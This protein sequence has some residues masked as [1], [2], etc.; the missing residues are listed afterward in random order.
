MVREVLTLS[1]GQAGI[2]LGQ[3][4]WEQYCAEHRIAENG[5]KIENDTADTT[6]TCFFQETNAGQY[7]PRNLMV[8][9]EPNV[10]DDVRN[11]QFC[12]IFHPEFLLNGKEDAANNFARGHYTV[13][14]DMMDKIRDRLRKLAD[15]CENL[16]GFLMNH[17]VGGGTGSGLGAL[18]LERIAMDYRKKSKIGFEIY[19]SPTM[20]TCVV[21]PYN[22]LLAT[23]WLTDHTEV[24]L[25]LDNEAIYEICQK[26]LDIKHPSYDNLNRLICK[27]ISSMTASLRFGG[28]LNVDLCEFQT[29]LV[30]FPRL[31]FMITAMAPI[32]TPKKIDVAATTV[33]ALTDSCFA[34]SN[35]FTKIADFDAQE[36]KY[37]AI[38]VSYRGSVNAKEASSTINW[39]K[40]KKKICF[41]DWVPT[42]FKV[43]LNQQPPAVLANDDVAPCKKNVVMIGNNTAIARVFSER[44]VKKYDVMYSQRAFVHWYVGE[45]MEEGELTE[46]REDLESLEKDY[47]DVLSEDASDRDDGNQ[48]EEEEDD[49]F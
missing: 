42:G 39:L 17:S 34:P 29:N 46:A 9:L 36:D 8:D 40:E 47:L 19:P 13:G 1:V 28:E 23:H 12:K 2:Q 10:I 48:D 15:N 27:T 21:E 6:F 44:I 38:S 22:A 49:D 16:Q 5:R 24:S 3:A 45:G 20:S 7:V 37:M 31:H 43:G 32:L 35:F 4:V 25:V 14:R 18:M 33:Q 41:V 26:W 30:P 11:S